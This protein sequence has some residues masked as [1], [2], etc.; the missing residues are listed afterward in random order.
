MPKDNDQQTNPIQPEPPPEGIRFATVFT[1]A[2]CC[3]AKD[4]CAQQIHDDCGQHIH[5]LVLILSYSALYTTL[6]N[7]ISVQK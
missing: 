2:P 4:K 3:I 7:R 6:Y 5:H 1:D